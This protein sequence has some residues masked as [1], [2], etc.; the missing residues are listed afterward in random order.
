[1]IQQQQNQKNNQ[2]PA[3]RMASNPLGLPTLDEW[4][5]IKEI[6]RFAVN[7]GM[8][9]SA[10]RTPEAAAV[11]A[12]KSKELGIPLMIGFSQIY[13]VNGKPSMSAELIQAMA[14]KNLPGLLINWLESTNTRCTVE[15]TRPE[16]GAKPTKVI[17][18]IE[19]AQKAGL[20]GKDI[21]KQY[22]AAMLRNRAIT[23]AL[24]FVCPDALMG[25]SYT[26][27]E[28]GIDDENA[29]AIETTGTHMTSEKEEPAKAE[30]H[31]EPV[32]PKPQIPDDTEM[33]ARK[34]VLK[35]I[36]AKSKEINKPWAEIAEYIQN[37]ISAVQDPLQL[38]LDQLHLVLNWLEE[39]AKDAGIASEGPAPWEQEA[40]PIP[41]VK[42][43][44]DARIVK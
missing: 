7:S 20:A 37:D 9:P 23:A 15:V 25:I 34:A 19:D 35:M 11:I 39:Q 24:R 41:V 30:T 6:A 1:M 42:P 8:L 43:V 12:L 40:P 36:M 17:W 16:R 38:N 2:L 27:E 18:T 21:W 14:R 3:Q 29:N 44:E 32:K 26:P 31:A 5:Q 10:I 4:N 22:P 28:L 13:I 33:K